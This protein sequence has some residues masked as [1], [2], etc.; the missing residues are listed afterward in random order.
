MTDKTDDKAEVAIDLSEEV[1]TEPFWLELRPGVQLQVMPAEGW[2]WSAAAA[3]AKRRVGEIMQAHDDVEETGAEIFSKIDLHDVDALEGY[4]RRLYAEGLARQVVVDWTGVGEDGE[5]AAV[6][7]DRVT[8]L[9]GIGQ[10]A[11]TFLTRYTARMDRVS[12]EGNGS[13]ASPSGTSATAPTTAQSA[14]NKTSRART[15]GK[16]STGKGARTSKTG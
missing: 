6:T 5:K 14:G 16:G 1:G 12:A 2:V 15:G 3:Y 10:H 7:K 13:G 9:M 8:R 4:S 11:E